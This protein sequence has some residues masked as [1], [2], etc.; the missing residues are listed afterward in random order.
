MEPGA[1][2]PL[3]THNVDA[4]MMI[5]SGSGEVLSDDPATNGR[6]VGPGDC[7]FFERLGKHGFR[8]LRI[9]MS[10]FSENGGIVDEEDDNNWDIEWDTESA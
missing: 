8:A 2:I 3:H 1:V 9:G 4:R 10:F 5:A 7:V 6:K